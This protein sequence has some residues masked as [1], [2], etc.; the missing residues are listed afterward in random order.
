M[1]CLT[2]LKY[3]LK[4]MQNELF[5]DNG[6]IINCLLKIWKRAWG[7]TLDSHDEGKATP[8]SLQSGDLWSYYNY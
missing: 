5:H 8:K 3:S 4:K 6:K 7:A 1:V 2:M